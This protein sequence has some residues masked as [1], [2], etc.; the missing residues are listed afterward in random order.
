MSESPYL[1]P[2]SVH[3][4]QETIKRSRF[5]TTLSH[6]PDADAA[7]AFVDEMRAE[8]GDATHNCWAFVTGPPGST[9]HVGMSD[10]HEP[11]GTAGKP[12]L[13]ALLHGGV[14]EIV[15]VCTRYYGGVKLGTGGL[16]RAYSSGVKLAL[17]ELPTDEKVQRIWADVEV[18]YEGVDALR[19]LVDEMSV[20][21]EAEDY[22]SS[23]RY[24]CGI[25]ERAFDPFTAAVA[26]ATRGE[27]TVRR[28]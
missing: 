12:M 28:V 22:G 23:V 8:F 3:R 17:A 11:H 18:G 9:A 19:R 21:V 1:I 15:A 20:V 13:T 7:K 10:D 2:A 27:G 25:P 4:V 14:G 16:S 6:A 24:R 5:I 26:D